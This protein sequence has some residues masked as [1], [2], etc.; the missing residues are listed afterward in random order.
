[1]EKNDRKEAVEFVMTL[2]LEKARKA[3]SARDYEKA[4]SEYRKATS[5]LRHNNISDE[6]IFAEYEDFVKRDPGFKKLAKVFIA[7]IKDNPGITEFDIAA[8]R[9]I[10]PW[11]EKY[12]YGKPVEPVDCSYFLAFGEKLGYIKKV[13]KE[14]GIYLELAK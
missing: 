1:M 3:V 12:G 11:G 4:R 13:E 6:K 10:E 9:I 8:M 7:G 2:H 14:D 5:I